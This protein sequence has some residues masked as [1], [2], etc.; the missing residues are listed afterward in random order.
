[1]IQ[2]AADKSFAV[3]GKNSGNRKI[4]GMILAEIQAVLKDTKNV[5]QDGWFW[6]SEQN[7]TSTK[8]LMGR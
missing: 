1:M 3:R 2:E 7:N 4:M 6:A 5:T 8:R